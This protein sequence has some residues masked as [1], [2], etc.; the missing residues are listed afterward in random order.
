MGSKKIY[1]I[2]IGV[3]FEYLIYGILISKGICAHYLKETEHVT[4]HFFKVTLRIV[5]M[6]QKG[7]LDPSVAM[8]L[9][10]KGGLTEPARV[11][12]G[13][14]RSLSVSDPKSPDESSP[15]EDV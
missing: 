8:H 4:Q 9:L 12:G 7:E 11:E 13:T 6:M 3:V 14:K 10:G 2:F 15:G 5:G 1:N